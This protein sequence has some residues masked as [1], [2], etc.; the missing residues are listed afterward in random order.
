MKTINKSDQIRALYKIYGP[1]LY[2]STRS[3]LAEI[4]ACCPYLNEDIA[5]ELFFNGELVITDIE[6]QIKSMYAQTVGDDG[7]TVTNPYS[8]P[9][10]V[11]ACTVFDGVYRNENT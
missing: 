1:L 9:G 7:P 10:R 8:G 5:L 6:S 4:M 2:L 11:Y 3:S